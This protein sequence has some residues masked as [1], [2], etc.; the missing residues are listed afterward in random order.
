MAGTN[1]ATNQL[2]VYKCLINDNLIKCEN[3]VYDINDTI[4]CMDG[5]KKRN[6]DVVFF[7]AFKNSKGVF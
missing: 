1:N 4:S 7:Y 6:G 3:K 5:V 2:H